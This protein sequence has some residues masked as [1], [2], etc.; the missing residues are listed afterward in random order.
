[1]KPLLVALFGWLL[2]LSLSCGSLSYAQT[3]AQQAALGTLHAIVIPISWDGTEPATTDW[4]RDVMFH[5]I[6][7]A[8]TRLSY[9]QMTI[10]GDVTPWVAVPHGAGCD[11]LFMGVIADSLVSNY[12]LDA[13]RW[14]VYPFSHTMTQCNFSGQAGGSTQFQARAW[15]NGTWLNW[16]VILHE[17][18][19]GLGPGLGHA[20][21]L[22]CAGVETPPC[23]SIE[24]G[25]PFDVM[26]SG[27]YVDGFDA[28]SLYV[29]GWL[30]AGQSP[31]LIEVSR[32]GTYRIDA[33]DTYTFGAK[34][35]KLFRSLDNVT[36]GLS[37][38]YYIEKRSTRS[39]VLIGTGAQSVLPDSSVSGSNNL[40]DM[41]PGDNNFSNAA[42]CLGCA[43]TL[44]RGITVT[45]VSEDQEGASI[46]IVGL[47][48]MPSGAGAPAMVRNLRMQQGD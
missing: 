10:D 32:D 9:R 8:Y 40:L 13:Y 23:I 33:L 15:I 39:G 12:L 29:L 27:T 37:T 34:A 1:M 2:V 28:Y 47:G 25:N 20:H 43:V 31:P 35:L 18:S 19:H 24:Y 45:L 36:T 14:K 3:P 42:L 44:Q 21:G 48:N 4:F 38:Y 6:A 16:N 7:D 11:Y 22:R 30:G 5:Q 17:M 41:T 46:T 26:G